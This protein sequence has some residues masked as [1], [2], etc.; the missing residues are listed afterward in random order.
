MSKGTELL[1]IESQPAVLTVNFEEVRAALEKRV[2]QYDIVVTADSVA[3]AKKLA[4]D[5]NKQKGEIEAKRKAAVAEVS[6]PIKGF[7]D[8]M[9]T[10]SGL[11]EEGR[12]KILVQVQR[13]EDESRE[14][15]KALLIELRT[16]LWDASNVDEEFRRAECE[17]LGE[18][19]TALTK[20]GNLSSSATGPL[21]QRVA[22]D[23]ALQDRTKMRLMDLENRS[24]KAG[25]KAPLSRDHVEHFLFAEDDAYETSIERILTT[26]VARQE[27]IEQ[28]ERDRAERQ[29]RMDEAAERRRAEEEAER[30]AKADQEAK[31]RAG[32][33]QDAARDS[34]PIPRTTEELEQEAPPSGV[35][36]EDPAPYHETP[37][38]PADGKTAWRVTC[39]FDLQVSSRIQPSAIEAEL[40][41]VLKE[42]GIST[43]TS[44]S[45]DKH[46]EAA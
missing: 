33:G 34:G 14:T 10:L 1:A 18:K 36:T 26:E 29:R 21:E 43:L 12:Q 46:R 4:T 41:R 27:Q 17:D 30:Q 24:Y 7:D 8:Q 31:H 44:V 28:Q 20:A 19:L 22:A 38:P 5:L 11:F 35:R 37:K 39:T 2:A 45:V 25:L 6:A 40:R 3:D 23:K 13:F 9:K 42:A 15:A 16:K 32:L